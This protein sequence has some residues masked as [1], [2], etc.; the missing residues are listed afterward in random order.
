[1][2]RDVKAASTVDKRQ[3][4]ETQKS[5]PSSKNKSE[6]IIELPTTKAPSGTTPASAQSKKAYYEAW[7][8]FDV[9]SFDYD[10]HK[11]YT[12]QVFVGC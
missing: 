2:L 6:E 11:L 8:K 3:Y 10:E 12:G 7:D 1:V 4:L 5:G 9:V